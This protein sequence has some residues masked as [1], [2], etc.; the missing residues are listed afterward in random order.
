M[1]RQCKLPRRQESKS[2]QP[3]AGSN[4][5]APKPAV[6]GSN[7]STKA[8]N[9]NRPDRR[10]YLRL[11]VDGH[12]RKVLL[13]TGSDVTLLPSFAVKGVQVEECDSRILAANG[14]AIKVKGRATVN[15]KGGAHEFQLTGLVTDHVVEIMIGIDFL[16]EHEAIWNFKTGEIQLDSYTHRL[17]SKGQTTWCRRVVLQ[18]DFV[19]PPRAEANLPTRIIYNDLTQ[20]Y[21][22]EQMQW[23]TEAHMMPCGLQV[24]GA[25]LPEGDVDIPVRVLNV[26]EYPITVSAGAVVSPLELVE[27]IDEGQEV[28]ETSS[29]EEDPVLVELVSRV[30]ESV[31][32]E[33]RGKLL[34]LLS[35]FS[36]TFS[37]DEDDMGR[38]EVITHVIDTGNNRPVR[39][40]LTASTATSPSAND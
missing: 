23:S 1:S 28:A 25:V 24:S 6:I 18:D 39:Q 40:A 12:A 4:S 11:N 19:V 35:E 34:S 8:Q 10:V 9:D 31:T 15:V 29:R 7:R 26:K 2:S 21:P 36:T 17:Q 33:E 37:R 30:D 20:V 5:A 32:E 13:D 22:K 16:H 14:T 27:V 38:T 3:A